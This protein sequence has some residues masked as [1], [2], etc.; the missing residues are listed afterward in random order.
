[1]PPEPRT[2]LELEL[3]TLAALPQ[4]VSALMTMY[5]RGDCN[6]P[7]QYAVYRGRGT[8]LRYWQ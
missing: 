4:A 3:E 1:M 7:N 2:E 8:W 5:D 6:E